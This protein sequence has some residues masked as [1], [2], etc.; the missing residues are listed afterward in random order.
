M[1]IVSPRNVPPNVFAVFDA[2]NG[3]SLYEGNEF[4]ATK[5]ESPYCFL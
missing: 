1:V 4:D 3:T 2:M 5:I